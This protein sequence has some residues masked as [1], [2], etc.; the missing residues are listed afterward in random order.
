[1]S[2]GRRAHPRAITCRVRIFTAGSL[3]GALDPGGARPRPPRAPPPR[4]R[5][6]GDSKRPLVSGPRIRR[7]A[8]GAGVSRPQAA[9]AGRRP[10]PPLRDPSLQTP[11]RGLPP[12]APCPASRQGRRQGYGRPPPTP[13]DARGVCSLGA[14]GPGGATPDPDARRLQPP[15]VCRALPS[16]GGPRSRG[17]GQ[18][19]A[20]GR[21]GHGPTRHG[22]TRYHKGR[23]GPPAGGVRAQPAVGTFLGVWL[24]PH[25][26]LRA[27][28]RKTASSLQRAAGMAVAPFGA[29]DLRQAAGRRALL[30]LSL[31]DW[32][33]F[34]VEG[35]AP[36]KPSADGGSGALA[37]HSI[38]R[39]GCCGDDKAPHQTRVRGHQTQRSI[40]GPGHRTGSAREGAWLRAPDSPVPCRPV[41]Y[42]KRLKSVRLFRQSTKGLHTMD[43]Q[44]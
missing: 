41:R 35:C 9:Q 15:R 17:A 32:S 43:R 23:P 4:A 5:S 37:Q 14:G 1:M 10:R 20:P 19:R 3:W 25:G 16:A 6:R 34:F 33:F 31:L 38:E 7:G 12:P 24:A 29:E 30:N 42:L 13:R 44:K 39:L 8:A 11:A 2:P 27:R 36:V 40:S 21:T 26:T 18:T 28:R 22:F